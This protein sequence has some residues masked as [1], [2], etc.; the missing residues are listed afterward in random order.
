MLQQQPRQR[1]SAAERREAI[2]DAALPLFAREGYGRASINDIV[3][4]T[5]VTKPV[6]YD[7]FASK[8]DLYLALLEREGALLM[9]SMMDGFDPE[10]PLDERLTHL[11]RAAIRFVRRRPDSARVVFRTPDGDEVTRDAHQRMRAAAHDITVRLILA[12][13]AF[14]ASPG[15]SRAASASLHAELQAATLE[16]LALW[17]LDHPSAPTTAMTGLFVDLLWNGLGH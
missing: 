16:R 12:D 3:V 11:A 7:H 1:L 4:A 2:L 13:P 17:A 8:R 6:V 9:S 5:T 10:S 14:E 15:L